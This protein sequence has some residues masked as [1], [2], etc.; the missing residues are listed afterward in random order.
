[1]ALGSSMDLLLTAHEPG[2]CAFRRNSC[3][4]A[5]QGRFLGHNR[6]GLCCMRK[7]ASDLRCY[8]WN[9][10]RAVQGPWLDECGPLV[11]PF[12][13]LLEPQHLGRDAVGLEQSGQFHGGALELGG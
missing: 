1:M 8:V 7:M 3:N 10:F 5:G 12:G 2:F 11:T 9:V 6:V 4:F 13:A